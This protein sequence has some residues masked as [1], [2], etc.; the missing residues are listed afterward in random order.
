MDQVQQHRRRQR[1]FRER[2]DIFN[3]FSDS[4]LIKRYRLDRAGIIAVTNLIRER[5]EGR[6]GRNKPLSPEL[7]V[8]I[9]LRYLATGRMQNFALEPR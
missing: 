8:A 7:K 4:E 1:N 9:T 2:R 6:G 5:L 3:E